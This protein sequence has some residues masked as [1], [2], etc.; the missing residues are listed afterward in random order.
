[1]SKITKTQVD[2]TDD[3]DVLMLQYNLTRSSDNYLKTSGSLWQYYRDEPDLNND[4]N[5]ANFPSN[6]VSI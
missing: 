4:G 5:I 6:I 1:M 3:L 2:Y